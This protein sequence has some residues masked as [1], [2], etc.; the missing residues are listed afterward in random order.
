MLETLNLD[1]LVKEPYDIRPNE[2]IE[3]SKGHVNDKEGVN[4]ITIQ[5]DMI[6]HKVFI[7]KSD[8]S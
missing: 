1:I 7:S 4:Y 5:G 3:L 8:W 6:K 2:R